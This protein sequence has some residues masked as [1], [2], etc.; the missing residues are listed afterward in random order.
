VYS[1]GGVQIRTNGKEAS[2]NLDI[3]N[4]SFTNSKQTLTT[5]PS[6]YAPV[7]NYIHSR[8]HPNNRDAWIEL[9]DNTIYKWASSANTIGVF[10]TIPTYPLHTP[11]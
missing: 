7:T 1:S 9:E 4:V 5:I 6:Q 2:I 10:C 3:S 8:A 11:L